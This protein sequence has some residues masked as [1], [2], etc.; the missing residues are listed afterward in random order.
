MND[1]EVLLPPVDPKTY[2]RVMRR[3]ETGMS[4]Q[5]KNKQEAMWS[6][7]LNG[8]LPHIGRSR[9][10]FRVLPSNPR[11][12]QCNV[13]FEGV[14]G[15]IARN[16]FGKSPSLGNPHY[17]NMCETFAQAHPGG[18]EIEMSMLFADVRGS[19]SLAEGMTASAFRDLMNRFYDVANDVLIKSDAWIDKLVGDEVIGFYIP[20]FS[21]GD[22]ARKAVLAA[23]NLLHATGHDRKSGPWVPVGV[24]VHTG[25][26][27][28]GNVGS[29]DKF[30]DV[31]A[32]GDAVNTAARL[33][34]RAG[35]GEVLVS[36]HAYLQSGL[37]IGGPDKRALELKGRSEA[38][39]VY[40]ITVK[41]DMER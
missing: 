14:G 37:S 38:V 39:S 8:E 25:T 29:H 9:H 5:E 3:K 20:G 24:G 31:T 27:F 10:L 41:P 18:A 34:S 16:F 21:G 23:R 30:A 15:L 2:E 6:A 1:D 36:E 32:L 19:T 11:C 7:L 13:P 40:T 33:A 26:A 28:F 22:H 12:K 35:T 4:E 17:C